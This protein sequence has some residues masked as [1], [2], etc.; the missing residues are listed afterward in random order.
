M[1]CMIVSFELYRFSPHK[2]IR[3]A[4]SIMCFETALQILTAVDHL[5]SREKEVR[6]CMIGPVQKIGSLCYCAKV[7]RL[8]CMYLQVKF[9]IFILMDPNDK[10]VTF[11][12]VEHFLCNCSTP[13]TN[14]NL[15]RLEGALHGII[16]NDLKRSTEEIDK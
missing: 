12:A 13:E 8:N 3:E 9:P 5:R 4:I 2:S 16:A 10:V 6:C 7:S 15:L 14:K 1:N 11:S